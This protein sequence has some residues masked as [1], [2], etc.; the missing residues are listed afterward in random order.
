MIEFKADYIEYLPY[1]KEHYLH[2]LDE[3]FYSAVNWYG[4]SVQETETKEGNVSQS[5]G[6]LEMVL[7]NVISKLDN[8]QNWVVNHD[9][10]DLR[11]FPND[12][13]NLKAIR[14]LFEV[15]DIPNSFIGALIALKEDLFNISHNLV[16][17]PYDLS[18]KNLDISHSE[19]QF[20][21]K[22]TSHLT[23]DLLST[24]KNLL[25]KVVSDDFLDSFK[26][27]KYR[28]SPA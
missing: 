17:Y 20:V 6:R 21:I 8:G 9:D 25:E 18:Y 5:K 24:D 11:W 28:I 7:K 2:S 15:N 23:I 3:E 12:D 16:S 1:D 13:N 26:K 10:K 19:L 4:Y 14:S 27:V 22:V